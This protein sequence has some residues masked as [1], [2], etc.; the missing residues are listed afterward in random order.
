MKLD[1][2]NRLVLKQNIRVRWDVEGN[3]N[4]KFF[5]AIINTRGYYS[6]LVGK[7]NKHFLTRVWIHSLS[8][9]V[10]NL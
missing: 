8:Q 7:E 1:T 3:E 9:H 4:T 6:T 2:T 5:H 10:L